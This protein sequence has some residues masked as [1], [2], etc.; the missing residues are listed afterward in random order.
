MK[1]FRSKRKEIIGEFNAYLMALQLGIPVYEKDARELIEEHNLGKWMTKALD[2]AV[3]IC[4]EKVIVQEELKAYEDAVMSGRIEYYYQATM[5][6]SKHNLS[7]NGIERAMKHAVPIRY[8]ILERAIGIFSEI[9]A[10][11]VEE[12]SALEYLIDKKERFEDAYFEFLPIVY[13]I[14]GKKSSKDKSSKDPDLIA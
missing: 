8:G 10:P 9:E 7:I 13:M 2:K 4:R 14:G 5:F 12:E 3:E 11:T 1:W 6:A